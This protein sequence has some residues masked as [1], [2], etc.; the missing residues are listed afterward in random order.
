LQSKG[1]ALDDPNT[2]SKTVSVKANSQAR[3]EWWGTAQD[4]QE[5]DMVFSATTSGGTPLQDSARP[6]WGK[7]PIL[8]YTAPQAFVTGGV[9]RGAATQ[10]EAVSLP[11]A[12][13]A[14]AGSGLDV[15]LSPSLAGSLLSALDAMEVPAYTTSAE[16]ITSY[17]LPN[18][19]IHR[20]LNREG[21]S[22]PAVSD[23]IETELNTNINRLVFLQNQD[24]GWSWWGHISPQANE[25][26]T[27]D[28]YI[29]A[30]VLLC[31]SR[32]QSIGA[33]VDQGVIDQAVT[34]LQGS[35]PRI[36]NDT[37]DSQLDDTAFVTFVLAQ[38]G[39]A[40]ISTPLTLFDARD[41]M[42]P[43]GK[44]WLAYAINNAY[45]ND[46]RVRDLVTDLET[47]AIRTAT[48]AHWENPGENI[49]TRGT[50]IYNTSAVV[51]AL[52]QIEPSNPILFDTVNYLTAHRN[53]RKLWNI[54][55]DNSWAILSL[56]EAMNAFGDLR[57][58][59]TFNAT[60]NGNQLTGGDIN[61][62]QL[63][64]LRANVPIEFL[65][66]E[67]PSLLTIQRDDGLGRLYYNATL[68]VNRPVQDAQP[69]NHGMSIERTY[70]LAERSEAQSKRCAPLSALKLD[71]TQPITAQLTLTLPHD[72]YYIIVEDFIP[73][74]T[75]I[76]DQN[77]KTSQ[78]GIDGTEIQTN[79]D[80]S[81]PFAE[82]W[83]WWLFNA[84][85]I[86]DDGITF[87]A[88]YLPAGTYTLT[89]TLVPTQ[90]GEFHV[91][92]ARA[93]QSFFPD[94]QGASAGTIIEIK[95]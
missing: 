40:D 50:P 92:P 74:G 39:N 17:L 90:A 52:S 66:V 84:P 79:F 83:G 19:E 78:L 42:S 85:Q 26:E 27:S 65:S 21:L 62:I 46:S 25:T 5:A 15:E 86:H 80:D 3:V 32:A 71:S 49:F 14:N 1:F 53:A 16:A 18:I 55:H 87:T 13:V 7:L 47:S 22:D 54:G 28:P 59:F 10:Q 34:F 41:R 2:A 77:L 8:Q 82:G 68:K 64:P 63:T 56:N 75:E 73:A 70:C 24:G 44:A 67:K 45:P 61:G 95:P 31:L 36:G 89:Y 35:M 30:Y 43:S 94:S 4:E 60:L 23:R 38:T 81:D 48:S 69:L 51:Y 88:N 93:W 72:S 29:T 6:V 11:R 9:L 76:L 33:E 58:D 12:F 91:M 37:K 57:S 20:S